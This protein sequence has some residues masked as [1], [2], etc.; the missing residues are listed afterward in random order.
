MLPIVRVV[1]VI[2]VVLNS[3]EV[4][5]NLLGND[6]KVGNRVF[7]AVIGRDNARIEESGNSGGK[8]GEVD[9]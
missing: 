3:T 5:G 9:W 6:I 8:I 7:R 4:T 2:R 1:V